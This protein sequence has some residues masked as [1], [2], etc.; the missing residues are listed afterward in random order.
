[1]SLYE[2]IWDLIGLFKVID[3]VIKSLVI[4][5]TPITLK[6]ARLYL[7]SDILHNSGTHVA[8]AWKYRAG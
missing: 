1:M 2:Y 6:L 3:I 7:V 4:P 5:E 8:N